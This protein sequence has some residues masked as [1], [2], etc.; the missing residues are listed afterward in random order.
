MVVEV[1]QVNKEDRA[2]LLS[3]S[4]HTPLYEYRVVT[5]RI[6]MRCG[7]SRQGI[8]AVGQF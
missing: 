3:R 7:G 2:G 6:G 5:D 1:H 8:Q 4:L